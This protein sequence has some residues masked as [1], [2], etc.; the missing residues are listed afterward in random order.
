[1]YPSDKDPMFG[2]F[3]E[4]FKIQ[5]EKQNVRFTCKAMIEGKKN[6][7]WNKLL[8]YQIHYFKILKYYLLCP[9]DVIYVHFLSHH[10]PI[11]WPILF[12]NKRPVVI[13]VHGSDLLIVI[14]NPILKNIS[15]PILKK[16]DLIVVPTEY[17]G[18]LILFHFPKINSDSIFISPSGGINRN[19]F[20]PL[21][22]T[23]FENNYLTIGYVSRFIEEKGW[24]I[25]IDALAQMNELKI[26]FK[27]KLVGKGPDEERIK[28][29]V[30]QK[31]L[32]SRVEILGFIPQIELPVL[33]NQLDVYV[34]PTF[35]ESES[36]GLTG[37]EAMSCGIPVIGSNLAGPATYIIDGYNGFLFT[38]KDSKSLFGKLIKFHK[39][40]WGKR[41][42]MSKNSIDTA[43]CYD[44]NLVSKKL[45]DKLVQLKNS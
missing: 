24:R 13:N 28:N 37:L 4:N 8:A 9:F 34:F 15:K 14:K 5:L 18:K 21:K 23:R 43:L 33:Y 3:I 12:C 26:N 7:I 25:F 1:M 27:A 20:K 30:F 35:R 29:Y 31:G 19:L 17:F 40:P 38:P 22:E 44:N 42:T 10:L 32:E 16:T 11:L 45:S 41:K 6:N 39:L 36:L 2:V